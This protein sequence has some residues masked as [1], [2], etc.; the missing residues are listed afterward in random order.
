MI[1]FCVVYWKN[2]EWIDCQLSHIAAYT[3]SK[4]QLLCM[5][6]GLEASDMQ[7]SRFSYAA[8]T[9]I[10]EHAVKL[11]ILGHEACRMSTSNEDILVFIDSDAFPIAK[12]EASCLAELKSHKLLAVQRLENLGDPQPHPCFCVTTV[13]FWREIGG[14][15]SSGHS[16]FNTRGEKVT[17]VGGNLGKHLER[18]GQPWRPLLRSNTYNPHPL[19]FGVYGNMIYHHGAGSRK[20]LSRFDRE[21]ISTS[22]RKKHP[23]RSGILDAIRKLPKRLRSARLLH[24]LG[25]KQHENVLLDAQEARLAKMSD[26]II[27][28]SRSTLLSPSVIDD[29]LKPEAQ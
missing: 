2:P 13:G 28:T 5:H 26:T 11:D 18:S 21:A 10:R 25:L 17:D 14:T 3:E 7:N 9:Q 4:Y 29:L 6:T 16:W 22:V 23:V 20:R 1:Y 15:W 27:R 24:A 19:W 8:N 12:W